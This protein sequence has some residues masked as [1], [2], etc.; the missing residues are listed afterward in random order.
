MIVGTVHSKS[1]CFA[2][3]VF[4]T[5]YRRSVITNAMLNDLEGWMSEVCE[6]FDVKL[7]EFNGEVDHVHLLVDFSPKTRLSDLIKVLKGRSSRL[8]RKK[9]WNS[10][11]ADLWG[12]SFWS[13]GYF[14]STAGGAPIK[15]LKQY[16]TNQVRPYD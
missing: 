9:Y 8:V 16:I 4:V 7:V 12:S 6:D 14:C 1:F 13:S 3:L 15:Y 11:K 10:L 5:K 2:H